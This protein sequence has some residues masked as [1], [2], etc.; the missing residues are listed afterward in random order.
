M[1]ALGL[2]EIELPARQQKVELHPLEVRNGLYMNYRRAKTLTKAHVDALAIMP[3]PVF[4]TNMEL[5]A[6]FA[7]Q[8]W[9]PSVFHLR[10]YTKVGGLL[11][12][13]DRTDWLSPQ[14]VHL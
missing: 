7:I 9:L 8:N 2:N 13:V 5:I 1:P 4:V 11:C 6:G 10:E 14:P 3:N 12:C